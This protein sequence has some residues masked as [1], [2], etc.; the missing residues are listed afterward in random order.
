MHAMYAGQRRLSS[1]RLAAALAAALASPVLAAAPPD[2]SRSGP[3]PVVDGRLWPLE[4]SLPLTEA[5]A[6]LQPGAAAAWDVFAA[7]SGGSWTAFVDTVSGRIDYFEGS[8][9]QWLP[10]SSAAALADDATTLQLLES[11]ARGL[12]A[13]LG[14]A[15][16]VDPARLVLSHQR[17]R[18]V[19]DS[20]WTVDFDHVLDGLPVEGAHVVFRVSH[21]RLIQLGTASLPAPDAVAPP[22]LVTRQSAL[23]A[24]GRHLGGF[25]PEA[26]ILDGGTQ[27]LLPTH[28]PAAAASALAPGPG[29][30][31]AAVWE[32]LFLLPGQPA[33][34]RA[35]VDA[36][37]GELREL[38]DL[39]R[40]AQATGGVYPQSYV[41]G[42]ETPRPLPFVDLSTGGFANGAGT[43][44]HGG[45][46]LSSTL[47]GKHLRVD[48]SCGAIS[49]AASGNGN[50]AFGTSPGTDCA[51]PGFG[52]AGNTHSARSLYYHLSE[53]QRT[54][55]GWFPGNGWLA[56]QLPARGNLEMTCN[57]FWNGTSVNFF[58]SGGGCGNTG[59]IVDVMLHELGHGIDAHDG[60]PPAGYD[61]ASGETFGDVT[62]MLHTRDSCIG[63]G[64]LQSGTCGPAADPCIQCTGVRD[65]D[66]GKHANNTPHTVANFIQPICPPHDF[67]VGPCGAHAIAT[68]RLEHRRQG[69]CESQVTSEA[70]WDV[71][72]RD[73]PGA[74]SAAAWAVLERLWYRSRPLARA[75][76]VCDTSPPVWTSHGCGT[77]TYW[78]ALRA[79]DDDDGN[80]A[81]GTPHSCQLFAAF[82]RHGIACAADPAAN[83][84]FAACTPPAQPAPA[85]AVDNNLVQLSWASSGPGVVYDVYRSGAGCNAGFAKVAEDLQATSFA[86]GEVANYFDYSYR[87]VAHPAGNEAC[88]ASPSACVTGQPIPCI[89]PGSPLTTN[90]GTAGDNAV[91]V[92]FTSGSPSAAR[93]NVYRALG[94]CASNHGFSAVATGVDGSSYLDASVSG[95]LT[96]AYRVAATDA[97]GVCE[98]PA[99]ACAQVTATGPCNAAPLFD[100]AASAA[101]AEQPTCGVDL[102]WTP[103]T[104]LCGPGVAYDVFRGTTPDF[105]P[106]PSNRIAEGWRGTAY[107]DRE[108]LVN[109][110]P[111]HYVVRAR[112]DANGAA[113]PNLVVRSAT[114]TGPITIETLTETFEAPGGFDLSGWQHSN[115]VSSPLGAPDWAW[116]DVGAGDRGWFA[117]ENEG[118]SGKVLVSPRF[119]IGPQTRL[120]FAHRFALQDSL[121]SICEDGGTLQLSIN[122]GVTWQQV[123]VASFMGGSFVAPV[124]PT[125]GNPLGNQPAWCGR[126][127]NGMS[128]VQVDLGAYAGVD[129]ARVRWYEGDDRMDV[130][131]APN[132]WFVDD[133]TIVN[134][135]RT[136]ACTSAAIQLFGDGF[137]S[138][139]FSRWLGGLVGA[140]SR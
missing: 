140:A 67:Y 18:R 85:I 29:R 119:G 15:L 17:S 113:D 70:L 64:F 12:L 115:V 37:T 48:D 68:N 7:T 124:D 101:N 105:T 33:T 58:R 10:K 104:S 60:T 72:V 120:T 61:F 138:G 77:D 24:V 122:G 118:P 87:V 79:V 90:A 97:T 111:A 31:L 14:P 129:E 82:A 93:Y 6:A 128:Q 3:A 123:P 43:Y 26:V 19:T 114:P 23:V 69:H 22:F 121:P 135:R 36:E 16:G 75:S 78:R 51:T 108:Q 30:G 116:V 39:N 127:M 94:T 55:R 81:N 95:T 73:L 65:V 52:G 40:Y 117:S 133:V 41:I 1:A 59:E 54:A 134:T 92:S 103:A 110:Q 76:F 139:D 74:G 38:Y 98:S 27:R 66:W 86:D 96:Y 137:E 112:H 63:D 20:L 57:A 89:T 83:V 106:S 131:A 102:A 5:R 62:A 2:P 34:W 53:L 13:S 32:I 42:G 11:R 28:D 126:Q 44:A 84:C 56:G 132:G 80:L 107:A 8:G 125:D 50:L 25:P 88:S 130:A 9:L 21:G 99:G 4:A 49:L 45:G 100:G 109:R 136:D 46:P 47:A 35:R 71:A 91:A